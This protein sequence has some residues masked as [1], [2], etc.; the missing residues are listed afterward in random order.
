MSGHSKWAQIKRKKAVVDQK[1]GKLFTKLIREITV[2]ARAG[3]GDATANARLRLA[4]DTAKAANMPQDNIE[5]AI[6]KG[7]GELEGARYDE[8]T[9][10]GY[11]P[12][13]AALLIEVVT[14]NA[15]RTVAELRHI[16]E[17]NGGHLG[18]SGSV[19][20]Q[21]DRKGQIYID[22]SRYHEDAVLEAALDAGADDVRQEG[23]EYIVTTEVAKFHHVQ[24]GLKKQ[25]IQAGHAELAM[26]PKVAVH[27]AG[28]EAERLLKLLDLLDEADDVQK[29]YSN[30]DIDDAVLAEAV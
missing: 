21:F 25:G 10:E 6:K 5:R 11:G 3:G 8:V 2:A 16:L 7:T 23:G 29:V 9:Y 30:C 17:R 1:R 24:E 20:W 26:I 22:A 12:G 18:Q 13:G 4:V 28:H 15:N 14:D 27:V 19:A